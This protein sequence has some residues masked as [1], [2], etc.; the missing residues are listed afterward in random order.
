M[1]LSLENQ[2]VKKLRTDIFNISS[3]PIALPT[4]KNRKILWLFCGWPTG[5]LVGDTKRM[6]HCIFARWAQNAFV[7]I[8][9]NVGVRLEL[10]ALTDILIG[11]CMLATFFMLRAAAAT[12]ATA[13]TATARTNGAGENKF[14]LM[15]QLPSLPLYSTI[16]PTHFVCVDCWCDVFVYRSPIGRCEWKT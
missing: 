15:I 1:M 8:S 14:R 3:H 4:K 13:T 16:A 6:L 7:Y 2:M 10:H 11:L 5:V 12:K 9:Y